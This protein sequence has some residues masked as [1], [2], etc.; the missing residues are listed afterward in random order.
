[1]LPAT[2]LARRGPVFAVAALFGFTSS[3]AR[4]QGVTF[5]GQA[6]DPKGGG[7]S[8]V[9]VTAFLVKG[10]TQTKTTDNMGAYKFGVQ[11]EDVLTL[12]FFDPLY[13][14]IYYDSLADMKNQHINVVFGL[15]PRTAGEVGARYTAIERFSDAVQWGHWHTDKA[16]PLIRA[17]LARGA[18]EELRALAE[19]KIDMPEEA[20]RRLKARGDLLMQAL[21]R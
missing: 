7:R 3:P 4:A 12:E 1:M 11:P 6:L 19:L 10:G 5:D 9:L 13:G 21:P 8:G 15:P 20:R 14:P 18:K 16:P 17:Y 2:H